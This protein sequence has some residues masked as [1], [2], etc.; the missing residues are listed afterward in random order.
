MDTAVMETTIGADDVLQLQ[1]ANVVVV[2]P[3]PDD[4]SL[5]AGGLV[6]MAIARGASVTVVL[7]TDGDCNPWPQ[8]VVEKRWR[9]G[10]TDRARWGRRRR[11]EAEQ[12]LSTLGVAPSAIHCLGWAD[13][14]L[15]A[16]L[17]LDMNA[18]T[19]TLA[20][21]LTRLLSRASASDMIVLPSLTD[22]HPDHGAARV[23]TELALACAALTPQLLGYTVHGTVDRSATRIHLD[24]A[25]Q[26]RK[27]A[28]VEQ[29]H[30]QLVLSRGRMRKY[31]ERPEHFSR[32]Q[33]RGNLLI[34]PYH[35]LPWKLGPVLR[36]MSELVVATA[37]GAWRLPLVDVT[38]DSVRDRP[39]IQRDGSRLTL[40][41]PQSLRN[42]T[43]VF[44]KLSARVPSPW[45]YDRW[46]W[47]RLGATEIVSPQ[48]R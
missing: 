4:E 48:T 40:V 34:A 45:I 35:I 33:H 29:H 1:D 20:T 44:V 30:T 19:R 38:G 21:L 43:P 31:A 3:H 32:E 37:T 26:R 14:G 7:L 39:S 46:G 36:Q 17:L 15:T 25:S 11:A 9:I 27:F 28:A 8:R 6:Q 10:A 16:R 23:M 12:A 42:Q 47:V 2:A 13:M 18:S 41:I 5:A 22:R 24:D